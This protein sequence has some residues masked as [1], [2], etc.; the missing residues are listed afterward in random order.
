MSG[1]AASTA[2]DAIGPD[3]TLSVPYKMRNTMIRTLFIGVLA[4]ATLAASLPA[5]AAEPGADAQMTNSPSMSA[6]QEVLAIEDAWVNAEIQRD[7]ATLRRVLDDRF[8]FNHG[9]GTT[10]GK[11][12]AIAGVLKWNLIGQTITERSVLMD[13]DTAIIFGTANFVFPAE[14]TDSGK[15]AGRYTSVYVRRDGTWRALA[16]HMSARAPN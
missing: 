7:E 11:E 2:D 10:T 16:L 6:E 9:N 4:G 12:E 3:L 14:G 1:A 5:M 8:T 15:S 13:G